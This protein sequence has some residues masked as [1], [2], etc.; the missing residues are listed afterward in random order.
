M[1]QVSATPTSDSGN[2]TNRK[3]KGGQRGNTWGGKP[4]SGNSEAIDE[5][6]NMSTTK[7][8]AA[9]GEAA[10]FRQ[11]MTSSSSDSRPNSFSAQADFSQVEVFACQS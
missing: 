1:S 6:R 5:R 3:D 2:S 7:K 9:R 4:R 10:Q 11:V 8:K